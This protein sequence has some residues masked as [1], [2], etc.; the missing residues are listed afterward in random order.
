MADSTIQRYLVHTRHE[1]Q[2]HS[3]HFALPTNK[4]HCPPLSSTPPVAR[5]S[6]ALLGVTEMPLLST[7]AMAFAIYS[8]RPP[9]PSLSHVAFFFQLYSVLYTCTTAILNVPGQTETCICTVALIA[10]SLVACSCSSHI[11]AS[12]PALLPFTPISCSY[13]ATEPGVG[14]QYSSKRHRHL[15]PPCRPYQ[16]PD[17]LWNY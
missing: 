12:I 9:L 1:H 8:P 11:S 17:K 13:F 6:V 4:L 2:S 5:R 7:P 10:Q 3:L 14:Y 15:S 16:A